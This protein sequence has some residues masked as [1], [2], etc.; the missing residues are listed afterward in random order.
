MKTDRLPRSLA[1]RADLAPRVRTLLE[2][3]LAEC[4]ARVEPLLRTGLTEFEQQLFKLAEQSRNNAEQQTAFESLRE[5]KRNRA[6]AASQLLS[7]LERRVA[8]IGLRSGGAAPRARFDLALVDHEEFDEA[9]ALDDIATRTELRV[10]PILFELGHRYGVL[11]ASPLLE[12]EALPLGPH[13][14]AHGF[15]DIASK[16]GLPRE[17]RML[18][19]RLCDRRVMGAAEFVYGGLNE[20]LAER[21]V[22]PNLRTFLPRRSPD[23]KPRKV[24]ADSKKPAPRHK[25]AH[26]PK[27]PID[28][29]AVDTGLSNLRE[30]LGQHRNAVSQP[31][32]E[33][34]SGDYTATAEE[35]QAALGALQGRASEPVT[36]GGREV[37]RTVQHLRHDMLSE[38]RRFAPDGRTPQF[39]AEHRDVLELVSLLFDRMLDETLSGGAAQRLLM[40][41][42]VPLLRV[43]LADSSFFTRRAHPARR[44]LNSV[45]ET[46]NVWLDSG[47]GEV[48]EVLA[49][50]LERV[51]G[52][53]LG[54]FT[55]DQSLLEK[56]VDDLESHVAGLRRRAEI[57]ERRQMEAAQGR[58]RLEQARTQAAAAIHER[59][60]GRKTTPLVRALLEQAWCDSLALSIL[61][62]GENSEAYHRRLA[63]ADELLRDPAERDNER[64][65]VEL[66]AGLAQIGLQGTEA[67][68]LAQR[69]LD[70]RPE[71]TAVHGDV[72]SQTELAV[73]LKTRQRLGEDET[74]QAEHEAV[75]LPLNAEEERVLTRLR[76]LPFGTWFEF[77]VNQQ[78]LRVQRKLAWYTLATNRCLLVNARGAPGPE[79]RLEQL[80]RLMVLDQARLLP[81][82]GESSLMDRAWS[83]LV[84]GL[85][86]TPGA[87]A[88]RQNENAGTETPATK[89]APGRT[90]RT[91]RVSSKP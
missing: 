26:E 58:D 8:A 89:G 29:V 40:N 35:L 17:H 22:L 72:P 33:P 77:I 66:E 69:V 27:P 68:Q 24:E 45:A 41:L 36:L 28:P 74:P 43:A 37:Q 25:A 19:Y 59:L 86:R 84:A 38:L 64:L 18:F 65:C 31:P 44:L 20:H 9:V 11:I 39:S 53:V 34:A 47:D 85:H 14:L 67:T 21:G 10:G 12:A 4:G 13:A 23:S 32:E 80:A 88:D 51:V 48:D 87:G 49:E 16:M 46:A 76:A 63:A 1:E 83:T 90:S 71:A 5:V 81:Q 7:S 61:R 70:L 52:R 42:Q 82:Q 57:A 2:E 78:G 50:K 56:L 62:H 6:D 91:T 79:R 54:E 3:Q 75:L 30:L 73:R 60:A 15:R 55:G